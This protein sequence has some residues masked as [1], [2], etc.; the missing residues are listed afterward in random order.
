[1]G[2]Q[3]PINID[4][5]SDYVPA[6]F[7]APIKGFTDAV[8]T[9][10]GAFLLRIGVAMDVS[11]ASFSPDSFDGF[12]SERE[13][14]L[15]GFQEKANNPIVL[16]GDSHDSWAYTLY[17]KGTLEEG[18]PVAVNLGCPGVTSPGWND[19]LGDILTPLSA[20]LSGALDVYKLASDTF[21]GRNDGLKYNEILRKG[22]VAVKATK[23]R[24]IGLYE[25]LQTTMDCLHDAAFSLN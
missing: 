18:N 1:M 21:V 14:L 6:P 12:A 4:K 9:D 3:I 15:D 16:S 22:F 19:L 11:G 23:V 24:S 8:L 13:I 25:F 17:E 10:P 20:A 5:M 2:P 7:A